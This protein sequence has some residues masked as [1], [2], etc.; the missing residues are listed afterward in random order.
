[1]PDD[2]RQ[3]SLGIWEKM[4]AG[5]EDDRRSVWESSRV[6]GEW[7]VDALDPQPRET[8]LELAPGVGDTGM[9]TA[10][11]L[12]PSGKL[13]S[14]DFSAQMVAAARR[15]AEELGASN[16]EFRTM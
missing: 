7:L 11:R 2:Y 4:A 16:V 5:W 1:M 10:A 12:G 6:V 9:A 8:G 14:T 15:R 3:A 13:I